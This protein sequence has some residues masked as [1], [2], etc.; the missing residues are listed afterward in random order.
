M[1]FHRLYNDPGIVCNT[2]LVTVFFLE[3]ANI[4]QIWRMWKEQSAIG[5][6]LVGWFMVWIAL[7]LWWNYYRVVAPAAQRRAYWVTAFGILMNS[8]VISTVIY[9]RYFKG[10]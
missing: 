3:A 2:P 1:N 7:V 8:V 9:F 5:Q 4:G 10:I 6:S